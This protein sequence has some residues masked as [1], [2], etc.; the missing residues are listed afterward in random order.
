LGF[1]GRVFPINP[2]YAAVLNRACYPSFAELPEAPDVAVFCLGHERVVDAFVAGAKAGMK[3]AV[4]YDG[5]FAEHSDAGRA[6]QAKIRA[7]CREHDIALCGPNCMGI[8]NP[9]HKSTTYLQELRDPTGLAGNVGILSHSGGLCVG[10]VTD[11]RRFGFSHIVSS[12]NEAAVTVAEFLEYLVE[13]PETQ[14]IGGFIETIRDKP[15]FA[16]ALDRAAVLGKPVVM[17]RVGRSERTRDAVVSHTGGPAERPEAIAELFAAHGVIEV[18]DVV[19]LT[20]TLAACQNATR[21]EGQR[22]AVI[23]SSGGLAELIL[24]IAE[25]TD[26]VLPPLTQAQRAEIETAIGFVT[27]DGNPCDAWGS[28]AFAANL[29]KALAMFDASPNHDAI[30]LLRDNFD[31]QPF[32]QPQVARAFLDLFIAAAK[33]SRKPHYLLTTRPGL[34]DRALVAHLREN[35]VAVV[36]GLREGLGAIDR[37]GRK[38]N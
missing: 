31:D 30:V 37:L 29:P 18:S 33:Q 36:G 17:L 28:G 1:A 3:A 20:E 19:E 21:P 8:L 23:T 4:I 10:L 11:T 14:V 7:I 22:L 2:N 34:M 38:T 27:G 12:G 16:A 35:G 5:G 25:R 15:R 26:L 24:D 9:H 13:E 32:D 6:R